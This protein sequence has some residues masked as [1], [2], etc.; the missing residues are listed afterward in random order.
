[1]KKFYILILLGFFQLGFSQLPD[2][3]LQVTTTNETCSGNGALSFSVTNTTVGASIVYSVYLLPNTTTPIAITPNSTLTGLSAGNYQ[4]VATQSLGADTNSQQQNVSISN[5]IQNLTFTISHQ[6]VKCG[7]DGILT[8]NVTSGTA[9]SYQLL[10]GP[11]TTPVQS[12]N[13]FNNLPI[14]N[15]SIRVFDTCGN[16]VVNSFTLTGNYTPFSIQGVSEEDLTCSTINLIASTNYSNGGVAYPLN[17]EFKVYPPNNATPIIYSQ[18]L[19]SYNNQGIEQIVPRYD[20]DYYYDVKI[21]D[22]CG[23]VTTKNNNLINIVF[24][25]SVA[26]LQGCSPKINISTVNAIYPY[27][28][29]FL[30]APAGYNPAAVNPGFPGPY[31]VPDLVLNVMLGNFTI[32]LTDACLKTHIVNFQVSNP[33]TPILAVAANNGCG[34]ISFSVDE[35]HEVTIEN[36][37]LVSAPPAYSGNLPQDLSVY[38][39]MNGYNWFHSGFPP[40]NYVFHILDSCGVLHVKNITVGPGQSVSVSTVY[41]PECELGRGS[42]YVSYSGVTI[43]DLKVLN[44]P[45]GFPFPLP[46]TI[47]N[48][49]TTA[50]TLENM[51]E[52]SYTIQMTT[53]C[54]NVQT[55]IFNVV[56]FVN[57]STTLEIQQFCS[58]F[59][60]RFS[61]QGNGFQVAYGLQK[62]NEVT[63]NWEH[64]ITGFQIIN[65]QIDASNFYSLSH[66]QWNIN[67]SFLGK[68]RI[69]KSYRKLN[70]DFCI[71]SIKEFEVLGQPKV[72][73]HN[74]V[75][76]GSGVSVVQLNA[77]GIGQLIY[78]ITLKDNQPF[79]VNNGTNNV[80]VNLQPAIYN[81]Q[82]EDS[83]GNILNHQIQINTS[84]PIQITPNLCENQLSNLS[85]DNYSFLQY[86][87]WKDGSP[88]TILSSTN[89]LTFN[90]FLSSTHSGIY[91]LKITHIGNPTSCLNNIMTYT[92]SG[93]ASPM[94]GLDNTVNFCGL[95][96][97]INLNSHLSGTFDLNGTWEEITTSNGILSNGIWDVTAVSYGVYKFKYTV[98]GFCNSTDEAIITININ[99]KPIIS[100][101]LPSYSVCSGDDL[102]VNPG[103]NNLNYSYQWTGPNSFSSTNSFLQFNVIQ[104]I[105]NGQYSLVV[106]NNGCFSDPFSFVIEVTSLPEFYISET[107]ENNIKTLAAI[108]LTGT[109]DSS[110]NFNWTGPNGFTSSLN[111]VQIEDEGNYLLTIDKNSCDISEDIT[112]ATMACEIPKGIS[113]NGDGLNE[114]FDLSGFDVN[115]IKIYN[116]YGKIVYSKDNGYAKEWYGQA[117]N[118]NILPDATYFYAITLDSGESK[119]GWVYVTR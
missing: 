4:V 101:L 29:E 72:L 39:N 64:P 77:V 1:M 83:C 81:F 102:L 76:C 48:A 61:H 88:S 6:K 84:F 50:F 17:V 85:A 27:T 66:N 28:V 15:Y 47:T 70:L 55:N 110:I 26:N 3:N 24:S 104:S 74:V 12:S 37:T 25:F 43:T 59:N 31:S 90:P 34:G 92:I 9:V 65:N 118:G 87:W 8:A 22:A 98:T 63:G 95:Q 82:I 79:L 97:S 78:R 100:A 52:G 33:E 113:P 75:N 46:Y 89:I 94:A 71:Q 117:D 53:D 99:E 23:N 2:F 36:V 80:F 105:S 86:E 116:R 96:S 44:A 42:L 10:T 30:I 114:Y 19:T 107:C 11:V 69:I 91:H 73:N 111:P 57:T 56:G 40:G 103:L 38:I 109:F 18:T 93:Q 106:G 115:A 16:A 20:G 35:I 62:L 51:P 13:V 119:T 58:S 49:T 32:K 21:I 7:N 41:Y 54:G 45:S 112:V 67:L 5:Q 60:L 108:P 68:F 14:G